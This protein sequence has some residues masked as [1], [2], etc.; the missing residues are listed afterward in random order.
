MKRTVATMLLLLCA[1]AAQAVQAAQAGSGPDEA[2]LQAVVELGRRQ[3]ER[4]LKQLAELRAGHGSSARLDYAEARTQLE[5]GDSAAALA[6]ADKLASRPGEQAHATLL[7][8]MVAA[9]QAQIKEAGEAAQR[10]AELLGPACQGEDLAT[11]RSAKDCDFRSLSEAQRILAVQQERRGAVT[12]AQT[13]YKHA[14]LLAE[15]GGDVDQAMQSAG[16]L[17]VISAEQA[18]RAEAHEWLQRARS[19]SGTDKMLQMHTRNFESMVSSRLGDQ[20]GRLHAL[21]ES[22]RLAREADAPRFIAREQNN[23]ADYY[24]HQDEPARALALSREALPVVLRYKDRRSER[25]LRHNISVALLQLKQVDAARREI[26]RVEELRRGQPDTTQ[27]INELRELGEAWASAGQPKEAIALFHLERQ[28]TAEANARNREAS[29]KQLQLKYDSTRERHDLDLLTRDRDLKDRQLSNRHL[30]QQLGIAVAVLMGLSLVLVGVMIK[31][32]RDANK[33]LRASQAL[34]RAQSER[35]P[36]TDLANR[37]HFLAVMEQQQSVMPAPAQFS[38][39]LLMVDIDHFKHVNDQHGHGIGD[40]VICEVARRLAH[41]VRTEDLVVRWGG[42]EFLVF[43]PDVGQEQLSLLAERILQTVGGSP[44]DTEDGPLRVT[45]SIGFAHFPLPP[46]QLPVH[47]E[48]AVNWADMALY[49]AKAQGRNRAMGIATVDARDTAALGEI[50][51]DFEAACSSERVRMT[52]VPG[53]GL[54]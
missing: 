40:V 38:G 11:L 21:Q 36:L 49:V 16:L 10:V 35:D 25:V 33:R 47:W 14:L 51:A 7:R 44:V 3:P 46:A 12:A 23:L 42:E 37:R 31:R 53:P 18:N 24:M 19:F 6:L 17:A 22:L 48:Q 41:A 39:A 15:A 27:R 1:V 2:Q 5:N 45:V 34:L 32:V 52:L 43:A 4:A 28:L 29:L 8:A 13:L 30:A 54:T 20:P 50:E 26:A 9:R